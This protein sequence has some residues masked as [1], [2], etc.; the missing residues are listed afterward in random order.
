MQNIFE[1]KSSNRPVPSQKNQNLKVIRT[2][3]VKCGCGTSKHFCY[4]TFLID[5]NNFIKF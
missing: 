2:N 5:V 3:Q 4:L 1:A